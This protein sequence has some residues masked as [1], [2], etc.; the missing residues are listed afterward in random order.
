METERL[1]SITISIPKV[2]RDQMRQIVAQTNLNNP[3][4]VATLSELGREIILAYLNTL[5]E[6]QTKGDSND[7]AI[8]IT[9]KG[10]EG[11]GN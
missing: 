6:E 9:K 10:E 5:N 1:V 7:R 11:Y 2:C 4:E 8:P 3:E